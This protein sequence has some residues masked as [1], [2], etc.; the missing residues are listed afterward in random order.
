MKSGKK[1]IKSN[2]TTLKTGNSTKKKKQLQKEITLKMKIIKLTQ[3]KQIEKRM[4][5]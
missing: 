2:K 1:A 4:K 5:I 3:S